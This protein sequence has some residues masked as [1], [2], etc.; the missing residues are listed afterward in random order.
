MTEL[1]KIADDQLVKAPRKALA[2]EKLIETWVAS[3]LKL[4]GIGGVVLGNQV[5]T[6]HGKYIDILAMDQ[7]GNTIIIELKRNRTPRD[8][9]AQVLD[10]ASW[11]CKLSTADVHELTHKYRGQ[12]LSELYQEC[13]GQSI[14]DTLNTSHQMLIVASEFDEDS[15][16][17]VEYLSEEHNVGIN[18][19]FF[20]IFEQDGSEWLTTDFLLDQE[21]VSERTT[22]RIRGPWTGYWYVNAGS[23][24]DRAWGD[25]RKYGFITASGGKW[26]SDCLSRLQVGD[27][28]FLYQKGSGYL[29]YG[30]VSSP[31]VMAK[32]F[33]TAEGLL[34][35][36]P[37]EQP[38]IKENSDDPE[39]A[40]YTVGVD[41]KTT[42]D[43]DK[44]KTFSGIFANQNIA[45]KIYKQGTVDF[46][47]QN[48]Q[49]LDE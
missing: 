22:K 38:A 31:R 3:D 45:C 15:K 26:Y 33:E 12:N 49:V 20:N 34:L 18:A 44:G 5:V 29:G 39:L 25:M 37:L 13:F 41:W 21:E 27:K 7:E 16:R 1:Y 6:D 14:P 48:F 43:R 46:L 23:E 9:V 36:Q 2:K 10:Y 19:S 11:V 24:K 32:E 17:I 8:V 40:A 28:I 47:I 30:I 4:V 42:F 35:E